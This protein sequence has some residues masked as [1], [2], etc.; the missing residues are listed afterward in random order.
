MQYLAGHSDPRTTRI[1][2]RRR[3]RSRGTSSSGSRSDHGGTPTLRQKSLPEM[4]GR[5]SH[6][7]LLHAI[8][9]RLLR[10]SR[11]RGLR[12]MTSP[13]SDRVDESA[14][15]IRDREVVLNGSRVHYLTAGDGPP[16]VLLHGLGDTARDWH[17]V[18]PALARRSR[19]I[20]PDFPG[21]GDSDRPRAAYSPGFFGTFVAGFLDALH[22]PSAV[23]AGNS[24]GGL[25][26]LR[27]ALADPA[28]VPALVLV[29]GAG[30]GRRV[31]PGMRVLS[32]PGLGEPATAFA[33]TRPGRALARTR[34][35]RALRLWGRTR[36]LFAH[37]AACPLDGSPIRTGSA[38]APT[39][40]GILWRYCARWSARPA[41]GRS[42]GI[43]CRSC[44]CRR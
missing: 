9:R 23:V 14:P 22:I 2:D 5:Q 19:V 17:W 13:G 6:D 12:G 28:R 8:D 29:D 31:N 40:S 39:S 1:Y 30:L 24:L 41:S 7:I 34:P 32:L 25:A 44:R 26:A 16:L 33:R 38:A 10:I 37:R 21:F 20:A 3:R 18:M 15:E 11:R 42:C 4:Y 35:G 27:F 43:A 36:S